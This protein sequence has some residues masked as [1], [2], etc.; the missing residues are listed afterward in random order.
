M[1]KRTHKK[2]YGRTQR[3]A[4]VGLIHAFVHRKGIASNLLKARKAGVS[5]S[6]IAELEEEYLKK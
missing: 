5:E 2:K 4:K 6:S 1:K 3:L